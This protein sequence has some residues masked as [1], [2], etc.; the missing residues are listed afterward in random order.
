MSFFNNGTNNGGIPFLY[1]FG[2]VWDN[3][4]LKNYH[5]SYEVFV[6]G[7][8][9]G[10]KELIAQ[11]ES[12]YD[13]DKH[14]KQHGFNDFSDE[15]VGNHVNIKTNDIEEARSIKQDLEVF[16]KIR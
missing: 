3:N 14:L 15:T 12:T 16:L 1:G 13:I 6:N 7:D 5:D 10:K 9:V 2:N 8:Y 4:N 11:N